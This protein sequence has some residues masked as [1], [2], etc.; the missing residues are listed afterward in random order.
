VPIDHRIGGED[1]R[2][3]FEEAAGVEKLSQPTEQLR[4]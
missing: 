4:P 2:F 1:G 3:D